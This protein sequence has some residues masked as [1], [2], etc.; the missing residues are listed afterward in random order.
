LACGAHHLCAALTTKL[1]LSLCLLCLTRVTAEDW[2]KASRVAADVRASV[3]TKVSRH[4]QTVGFHRIFKEA[5]P[6][7]RSNPRVRTG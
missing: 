1:H 3:S 7:R 4:Q 6:G 2:L 5:A